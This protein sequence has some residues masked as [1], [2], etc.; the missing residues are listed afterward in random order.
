MRGRAAALVALLLA[1]CGSG[2]PEPGAYTQARR[3]A[4][5]IQVPPAPPVTTVYI[6]PGTPIH[7]PPAVCDT[8]YCR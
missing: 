4:P 1:A 3:P 2:E 6:T 7:P 5:V 8:S